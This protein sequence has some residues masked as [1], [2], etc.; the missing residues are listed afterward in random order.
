MILVIFTIMFMSSGASGGTT[1][2]SI[3][4]NREVYNVVVEGAAGDGRTDDGKA[5]QRAWILACRTP[6]AVVYVPAEGRF[7]L[8]PS[9]FEGPCASNLL[10]LVEGTI[11]AM[12]GPGSGTGKHTAWLQ[13]KNLLN[14]SLAGSGKI[15]GKGNRW[16]NHVCR[17]TMKNCNQRAE[18][19]PNGLVFQNC[20][21]VRVKNLR[22]RDSPKFHLTFTECNGVYVSGLLITAP[23]NSPNTDGIHLRSSRNVF[24]L[25]CRI[26]TGDDC[27]SIQTGSNRVLIED[28]TCGPGHGISVGSLG[29]SGTGACV[30][31]IRVDRAIFDHSTNGFRIKTWQGGSGHAHGMKFVNARMNKVE[32]PVV[33]DQYYCDS[34]TPCANK[35]SAVAVSEIVLANI[36]G[37]SASS[38]AVG[39]KCSDYVPCRNIVLQNITVKKESD[40]NGS[41]AEF[42]CWNAYGF[43]TD[44]TGPMSC[45]LLPQATDDLLVNRSG[46]HLYHLPEGCRL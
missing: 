28:I 37:T 34:A 21:N 45:T 38:I 6:S 26:R 36:T 17:R 42:S 7:S 41:S 20:V 35:T 11:L 12:E 15:N 39:I 22:I 32:N 46:K 9:V 13:F 10:P 44:I 19:P 2:I 18:E 1:N 25:N 27:V 14:F 31:G 29:K 40:P 4:G 33:I 23:K 16:W 8:R 5:F 24:I 43:F 3:N 30:W